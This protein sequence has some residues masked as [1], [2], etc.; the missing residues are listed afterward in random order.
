MIAHSKAKPKSDESM[1]DAPRHISYLCPT[2]PEEGPKYT[3]LSLNR[4]TEP[5]LY[6]LDNGILKLLLI[7]RNITKLTETVL[8]SF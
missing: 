5:N 8:V 2:S 3:F 7:K 4:K 1:N 6:I